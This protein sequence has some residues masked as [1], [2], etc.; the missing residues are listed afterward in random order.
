[1]NC[2]ACSGG[3]NLIFAISLM[4]FVMANWYLRCWKI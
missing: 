2:N 4:L 1:M 3:S